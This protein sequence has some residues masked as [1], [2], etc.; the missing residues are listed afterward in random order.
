VVNAG[1]VRFAEDTISHIK[2]KGSKEMLNAQLSSVRENTL[3]PVWNE[4]FEFTVKDF[5]QTKFAVYVTF[6]PVFFFQPAGGRCT[7]ECARGRASLSKPRMVFDRLA[8]VCLLAM[9]GSRTTETPKVLTW[10]A[11]SKRHGKVQHYVMPRQ[12]NVSRFTSRPS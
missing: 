9:F 2:H 4:H 6:V 10:A 11:V 12:Y 1:C 5:Q 3:D 7:F 8:F